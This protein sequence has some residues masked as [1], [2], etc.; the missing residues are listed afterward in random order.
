[1]SRTTAPA[2]TCT[3]ACSALLSRRRAKRDKIYSSSRGAIKVFHYFRHGFYKNCTA[4]RWPS[5]REKIGDL[6]CS[7][8]SFSMSSLRFGLLCAYARCLPDLKW[9]FVF[10]VFSELKTLC[11]YKM[12]YHFQSERC[13]T[14]LIFSLRSSYVF[15]IM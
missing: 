8:V 13:V 3:R 4:P 1:M 6:A 9:N 11:T 5:T 7:R 14:F 15:D 2:M 10:P 12:C